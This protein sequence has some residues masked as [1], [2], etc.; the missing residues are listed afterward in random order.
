MN[1]YLTIYETH[2]MIKFL[3]SRIFTWVEILW[4]GTDLPF[5]F[6]IIASKYFILLA[7]ASI[8]FSNSIN[9]FS[10]LCISH[11]SS[12]STLPRLST[13]SS[14]EN[15]NIKLSKTFNILT[16]SSTLF[17]CS[18]IVFTSST[19]SLTLQ[20]DHENCIWEEDREEELKPSLNIKFVLK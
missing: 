2:T 14:W 16:F 20:V 12:R 5:L 15:Q 10:R 18:N 4:Q 8:S 11:L 6:M 13:S 1:V 17:N 7:L 19:S 9:L 3:F